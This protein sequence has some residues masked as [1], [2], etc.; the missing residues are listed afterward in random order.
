MS[1]SLSHFLG[2][3]AEWMC[4]CFKAT[5]TL[6]ET[7]QRKSHKIYRISKLSRSKR[8]RE[9]FTRCMFAFAQT[10]THRVY[11]N[12]HRELVSLVGLWKMDCFWLLLCN[13]RK[14]K[15]TQANF[16]RY[17]HE[18]PNQPCDKAAFISCYVLLVWRVFGVQQH[19]EI[20][21]FDLDGI[22]VLCT[23]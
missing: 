18:T 22:R 3:S 13:G 20:H 8:K 14:P 23:K 12:V 16:H 21:M 9:E 15:N 11:T 10:H 17:V 6:L 7:E 1:F 5:I 4:V 2:V 19:S